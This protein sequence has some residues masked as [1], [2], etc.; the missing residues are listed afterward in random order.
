M[1]QFKAPIR[2]RP[3]DRLVLVAGTKLGRQIS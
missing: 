3:S 2:S 1:V